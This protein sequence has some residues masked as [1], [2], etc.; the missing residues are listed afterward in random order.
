[1]RSGGKQYFTAAELAELKLPGLPKAKRKI[2]EL[3]LKERW[4]LA[5]DETG[6]PLALKRSGRGGGLEYHLSLLPASARIELAKVTGIANDE[7]PAPC[8]SRSADRIGSWAWYERQS[9]SAKAEAERR[10]RAIQRLE[11]LEAGG[12]TRSAAV[13]CVA[14]ESET[15]GSTLWLWLQMIDGADRADRLP[16]LAPRR[17]GGGAEAEIDDEAWR[18]LLSDFLRPE[19]PTWSSCYRRMV[20]RFAKPR[21]IT[22]PCSRTLY[23]KLERE[24]DGRLVVA[25]RNGAEALMRAVPPQKRSVA[26]L[27]AMHSVNIDGHRFDVFCRWPDGRVGRPMMVAIQDLFSRKFV[28]WR[29]GESESAVLTRLAF[30]DVFQKYGIPGECYLDNGRAFASKLITGGAKSRFRFK[31]RDEEPSGLLTAL[32]IRIHWTTPYSGQ[33]KPIERAFRDLCDTIAKDPDLAG[34]Y[35]GNKVDAKPENYGSRAV[36]IDLFERVVE[37][38]MVEHNARL[39]RRTETA[40]GQSFDQVFAASYAS[41]PIGKATDAQLRLALL[42]SEVIRSDRRSGAV[43]L[44]GNTYWCEELSLRAGQ[45]VTV[46]FDPDDLTLPVHVYDVEDR[47]LVTAEAIE[48]TEF[49]NAAAAQRRA[50]QKRDLVKQTR[51]LG[52]MERLMSA[53][54]LAALAARYAAEEEPLPEATV[55]RPI[56]PRRGNAAV[57]QAPEQQPEAAVIDRMAAAAETRRLRLVQE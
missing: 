7:G 29:I 13:A 11:A 28:G 19:Q 49:D 54:Q 1:M 39:G 32:G 2:N 35:T 56:R 51:K 9:Q 17:S 34:A 22:V 4:A 44:M 15:S 33:S 24:V 26:H 50:R 37:R 47:F 5:T 41:A 20:D 14:A 27:H 8:A 3:A 55:V 43:T 25:R 23:R 6:A 21:G 18:F 16:H 53:E 48:I 52:E 31:I 45:K 40:N 57:A 46:R 42:A 36:P 30:A 10:L 12:L 38:G